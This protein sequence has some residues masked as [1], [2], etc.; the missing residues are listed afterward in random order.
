MIVLMAGL[1]GTGKSSLARALSE[2]LTGT[3]LSKDEIRHVLFT[4]RDLAYTTEQDDLVMGT[5]LQAAGWICRADPKRYVILDG[6]TFSRRY[7]VDRVFDFAN[8]IGQQCR[9][10]ECACSAET[11][12][13]R[14]AY[15]AGAGEHP[16]GN[17]TFDLY[18]EIRARFEAITRPKTVIDTDET[19]EACVRHALTAILGT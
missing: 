3:V 19:M 1:P 17:R 18:L 4:P 2:R 12:R 11:A 7:Q 8:S 13:S 16:A 14:L 5:V 15:Q 9:I 10:L 6:R